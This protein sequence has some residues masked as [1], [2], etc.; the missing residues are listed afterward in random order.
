MTAGS[1]LELAAIA[2]AVV[3]GVSTLGGSGTVLG[4]FLGAVLIAVLDQ[5]LVRVEQISEF[6]RD[7]ILGALIVL[8][9]LLDVALGR[10]LRASAGRRS[11][12]K[13][14]VSRARHRARFHKERAV[15]EW[16]CR[17]TW[18]LLLGAV[19]VGT[20]IFNVTQSSG[21]LSVD[22][23]VNLFELHIEKVIVVVTMTFVIIAGEIDLSV[24]SVMAWSAAV[25]AS[26][27]EHDVPLA[28]AIVVALAAAGV[29]GLIHGFL[30]ARVGLP[31][32]VVTLAGLIGWR[33]AAR[34]LVEDR[35]IG[36]FPSW[37]DRLGQ[38]D[39]VGPLPLAVVIFLVLFAVGW[40]VLDR[41]ATG[42]V[43]YVIGDNADVARYSAVNVVR[44]R[45]G[46]FLASSLAAGLAGVLFAARL[47]T[48]R[49]D[50]ATGFELEIITI[51]LLGGVSI[52]GGS[53][54]MSG[55]ALA[56]LIVLNLRNGFGLANVGGNT[57]TGVIGAILICSVLARNGIDRLHG[58]A[59]AARSRPPGSAV[60]AST[61]P[62][63]T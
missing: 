55:V 47:G 14:D 36:D 15:A 28:A 6:W 29:V 38:Q 60:A 40:V 11:S 21:Y 22:N 54:R 51:V 56:V 59:I 39:L 13:R 33:G 44:T 27:H 57:Q 49:G 24:A 17:N 46:L 2:A 4:A 7:A 23:F 1:G 45:F 3:G 41:T 10:R 53:G 43:L 31:S 9:V 37:F 52:F 20:V 5:S 35:S 12:A 26:L 8:A 32:L 61:E 50:L 16:A 58:R 34:V 18:N 30:I 63:G 62:A 48:V 19:L 25:L 42:R